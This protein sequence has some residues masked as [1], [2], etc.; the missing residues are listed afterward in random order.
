M[1]LRPGRPFFFVC[2]ILTAL[3]VLF[4]GCSRPVAGKASPD[5]AKIPRI[6]REEQTARNYVNH[7]MNFDYHN[8]DEFGRNMSTG[9]SGDLAK[10]TQP[11]Q[12]NAIKQL[13]TTLEAVSTFQLFS[14]SVLE[15]NAD[16]AVVTVAGQQTLALKGDKSPRVMS[17]IIKVTV[18]KADQTLS[19]LESLGQD[20]RPTGGGVLPTPPR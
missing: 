16:R 17:T 2:V 10:T 18:Q 1:R 11:D 3:A 7:M 14:S 19:S 12:L 9:I 5:F 8:M 15:D 20:G 13:F 4:A 6:T